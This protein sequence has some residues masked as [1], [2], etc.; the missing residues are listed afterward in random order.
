[1]SDGTGAVWFRG[2]GE[3]A[4]ATEWRWIGLSLD[5]VQLRHDRSRERESSREL[6]V[7]HA[8]LSHEGV[9]VE[10]VGGS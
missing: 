1:M 10:G 4:G 3:L 5:C 2:R 6:A 9:E 8:R 7:V